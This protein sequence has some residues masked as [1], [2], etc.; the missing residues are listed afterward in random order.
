LAST[1]EGYLAELRT[2]LVGAD[3]ALVQD[4]TYDAEEY[5]RSSSAEAGGTPEAVAAAI[6]AYGSPE[7]VAE[8]YRQAED[9]VAAA[10]RRPKPA[11]S[12]SAFGQSAFGRLFGVIID[13]TAYAA[14][15]Y[16]LLALVTGI[17][18][19][20]VVVTGISTTLG[21]L[22][23]IIGIPI[24]LLFIA[25]IRAISLA[26]GRIVEGL[27]G[28]RMPRRPRM[29]GVQ[30]NLWERIKSWLADY[31]TWTTMLYMVLQLPLGIIYFTLMVTGLSTSFA[32]LTAPIWQRVYHIP[33]WVN[34]DY[35]YYTHPAA[36]PLVMAVGALGFFLTLW[37]AKGIGI[38]HGMW[39]KTMLVGRFDSPGPTSPAVQM[40][41][42]QVDQ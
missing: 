22:I 39:A 10:L 28:V 17:I 32:L 18:Y 9:T 14:M 36:L 16:A 37:L 11:A 31:R 26:E 7:E 3:P 34:G 15:F 29:A 41:S 20:T 33:M 25:M 21:L 8:A 42:T 35:G 38:V 2:A 5:L 1:V 4:A 6:D 30:G 13:P 12:K 19:F 23:L 24:A 27:L 40:Q